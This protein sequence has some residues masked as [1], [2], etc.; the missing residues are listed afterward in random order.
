MS[1]IVLFGGQRTVCSFRP[2]GILK[3]DDFAHGKKSIWERVATLS[4]L[5]EVTWFGSISVCSWRLWKQSNAQV[6][7][8]ITSNVYLLDLCVLNIG[9]T[10]I[11]FWIWMC[12]RIFSTHLHEHVSGW[13]T[14]TPFPFAFKCWIL[15]LMPP[16]HAKKKHKT[17]TPSWWLTHGLIYIYT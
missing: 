2:V 17:N 12:N 4:S 15:L 13:L 3:K 10:F 9:F 8:K 7:V 5:L 16:A 11:S 14:L 6:E 1:F